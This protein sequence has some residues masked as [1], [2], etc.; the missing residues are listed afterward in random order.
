LEIETLHNKLSAYLEASKNE[1]H[2][3]VVIQS[4]SKPK[5]SLESIASDFYDI[6]KVYPELFSNDTTLKYDALGAIEINE[7]FKKLIARTN[8]F[9]GNKFPAY[10]LEKDSYQI[11]D[12]FLFKDFLNNYDSGN[13]EKPA[14]E[15]LGHIRHLSDNQ[16][17]KVDL[18]YMNYLDAMNKEFAKSS[19][20]WSGGLGNWA[21]EKSFGFFSESFWNEKLHKE[22]NEALNMQGYIGFDTLPFYEGR[23]F[24]GRFPKIPNSLMFAFGLLFPVIRTKI[25]CKYLKRDYDVLDFG[26]NV[27]SCAGGIITDFIHPW[28]YPLRLF[29]VPFVMEPL[30]KI[31]KIYDETR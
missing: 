5:D 30:R 17:I 10:F 25:L 28:V 13:D 4:D 29:G 8:E 11:K 23:N 26:E 14:D 3:P 2:E 1:N 7:D 21:E 31:F 9:A 22:V 12:L 27:F 18:A 6:I 16:L 15:G 20:F 19:K 24:K